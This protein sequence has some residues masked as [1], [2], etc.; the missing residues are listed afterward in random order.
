MSSDKEYEFREEN[1]DKYQDSE[2][3]KFVETTLS[4]SLTNV[5][6]NVIHDI[7]N[8]VINDVNDDEDYREYYLE[9]GG[10]IRRSR[11]S[12][13]AGIVRNKTLL[14]AILYAVLLT[15]YLV[16]FGFSMYHSFGDEGSVRL[17][18]A[19][20]F[21]LLVI[22]KVNFWTRIRQCLNVVPS[23]QRKGLQAYPRLA[24]GIRWSLYVAMGIF[25]VTYLGINA[26]NS[27]SHNLIPLGGLTFF[28]VVGFL[29]SKHPD[30][31]NWHAVF[32]GIG[33]QFLCALLILR[34]TAGY[35]LF[36]WLGERVEEFLKHTDKGSVFVFGQSYRDHKFVF[37][38]MPLVITMSATVNVLYHYGVLQ[39]FVANFG[40]FLTFCLGT[41][42]IASVNAALNMFLGPAEAPISVKPYLN[43]VTPSEMHAIMAAGFASISGS[44]FGM[45]T[46]FG[47]PANHLLAASIMSAPAALAIAKLMVPETRWTKIK[48]KDA[49]TIKTSKFRNVLEALSVGAVD[50]IKLV[51][52]IVVNQ[53]VFIAVI[54]FIDT[55]L[56]WL[57]ER[58]GVH[59]VSF[60]LICSYLFYPLT[61]L[62]GFS[63]SDL[64]KMGE[65]LGI[66]I[67]ANSFV[68][69]REFGK[70]VLNRVDLEEY[71]TSTNGSWHWEGGNVI[72]DS[73]NMTL[74][75][76]ILTRRSEVIG[77]YA[78]CGLNHLGA[79]GV[80]MGVLTALAP[81]RK[82]VISKYVV[83][84]N[85]TGQIACFMTACIAG[86]LYSPDKE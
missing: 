60:T 37:A 65:L 31:V 70:L 7:N 74:I 43:L 28:I 53:I 33:T 36:F 21:V 42:P 24:R 1:T 83:R 10:V 9:C 2:K 56:M 62:M 39:A 6:N 51:A 4:T 77:T 35:N 84:A 13:W 79:V 14:K 22:V 16:Y 64:F 38:V 34:T 52:T 81:S 44:V 11:V 29:M 20:I 5:N 78:M 59:G 47:A 80:T 61:Y 68:G 54:Q 40:W 19:S 72:L 15:A 8:D 17:L 46:S 69:F 71:V 30:R 23:K 27:G 75:G 55:A 67:F 25:V 73:T 85:I 32:W 76:G 26:A 86:M 49:Y 48:P 50:G 18:L 82:D 57:G 66:K 12:L 58:A 63:S 3:G 45:L 41:S